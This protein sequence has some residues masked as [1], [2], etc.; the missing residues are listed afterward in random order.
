MNGV[1]A[2]R[3]KLTRTN[4][5]L[6]G[7]M[8]TSP[9][10]WID[11]LVSSPGH[12][13]TVGEVPT[14]LCIGKRRKRSKKRKKRKKKK[15]KRQLENTTCQEKNS[16]PTMMGWTLN[17]RPQ[18]IAMWRERARSRRR[19]DGPGVGPLSMPFPIC[20]GK[21]CVNLVFRHRSEKAG[22]AGAAVEERRRRRKVRVGSASTGRLQSPVAAALT[23]D[24]FFFFSF[25][26][27]PPGSCSHPTTIQAGAAPRHSIT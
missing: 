14:L 22:K 20:Q 2:G 17:S 25:P 19:E 24:F 12:K 23:G 13:E 10:G 18:K 9:A 4:A 27:S 11:G 1:A 5:G 26:P 3:E 7:G 15:K 6:H 16:W 8:S 21:Y